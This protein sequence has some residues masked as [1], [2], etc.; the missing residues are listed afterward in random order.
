MGKKYSKKVHLE[1]LREGWAQSLLDR[2]GG[3]LFEELQGAKELLA[4]AVTNCRRHLATNPLTEVVAKAAAEE[5][6][7]GGSSS[8]TVN[9][10]GTILLEVN[11]KQPG[12]RRTWKTTLPPI[13]ELR[14]E[15]EE[16]KLDISGLGRSRRKI[17]EAIQAAKEEGAPPKPKKAKRKKMT[18]TG[19]A[20]TPPRVVQPGDLPFDETSELPEDLFDSDSTDPKSPDMQAAVAESD[21]LDLDAILDDP[22]D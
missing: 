15:A 6:G 7:R 2:S 13:K 20:I 16:M 22:N 14:A 3:S 18:K 9:D 11:P 21:G 8:I 4:A 12:E 1:P 19:D 17:H 10:Q 5:S